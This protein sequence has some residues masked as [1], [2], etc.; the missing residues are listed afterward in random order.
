[1]TA[2]GSYQLF[3]WNFFFLFSLFLPYTC[4]FYGQAVLAAITFGALFLV[5]NPSSEV[6]GFVNN[7]GWVE[8]HIL[9]ASSAS[10][11][12]FS[13]PGTT[14]SLQNHTNFAD[15]LPEIISI[16][17]PLNHNSAV[18]FKDGILVFTE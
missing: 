7:F 13:L 10:A 2:K 15:P 6:T 1:M 17:E 14:D 11:E 8:Q 12:F 18:T 16:S 4:R 5:I 3:I 9:I